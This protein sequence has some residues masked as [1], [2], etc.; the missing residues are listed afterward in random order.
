MENGLPNGSNSSPNDHSRRRK[1]KIH[2][3]GIPITESEGSREGSCDFLRGFLR[4][5]SWLP[6]KEVLM[7]CSGTKIQREQ[8]PPRC[9]QSVGCRIR[10]SDASKNR[11]LEV[12]TALNRTEWRPIGCLSTMWSVRKPH[13]NIRAK[14]S[15]SWM[16][17]VLIQKLQRWV[18]GPIG[19][20]ASD[21]CI[22]S[23]CCL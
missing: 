19:D 3:S 12:L 22:M 9:V 15:D 7:S 2:C 14:F 6:S 16:V 5:P 21:G 20:R 23:I 17:M 1:L 10:K 8:R 13:I 18:Q 4:L 11:V